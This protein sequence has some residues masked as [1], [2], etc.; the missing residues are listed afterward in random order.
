L[1]ADHQDLAEYF[2]KDKRNKYA[3]KLQAEKKETSTMS[4]KAQ[5]RRMSHTQSS[6]ISRR[7]GL[8]TAT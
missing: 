4:F 1:L 6:P 2:L 3:K 5:L 7:T 8:T